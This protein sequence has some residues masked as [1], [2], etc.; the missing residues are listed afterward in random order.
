MARGYGDST[1]PHLSPVNLPLPLSLHPQPS[2]SP[3]PSP[4]TLPLTHTH[5]HTHTVSLTHT[6]ALSLSHTHT[7]S[8][9]PTRYNGSTYALKLQLVFDMQH[10]GQ[11][12]DNTGYAAP[13][14]RA[15]H[16]VRPCMYSYLDMHAPCTRHPCAV[17]APCM[18]RACAAQ[19]RHLDEAAGGPG[20][21]GLLVLRGREVSRGP[22]LR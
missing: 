13:P 2:P 16:G 22:Q 4:F 17:H 10:T 11:H 3:S 21:R 8:L 18:R 19:V 14:K 5:T 6:H 20:A 15:T 12:F 9:T 1:H 7:L